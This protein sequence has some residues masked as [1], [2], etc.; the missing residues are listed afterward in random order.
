MVNDKILEDLINQENED[1][2]TVNQ[3]R[4]ITIKLH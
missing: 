1:F 2:N 3:Y 4:A